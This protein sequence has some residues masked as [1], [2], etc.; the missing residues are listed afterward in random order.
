MLLT[1][2]NKKIINSLNYEELLRKWRFAKFNDTWLM[3]E[4]GSYWEECMIFL[5]R[6]NPEEAVRISKK[7]GW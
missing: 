7:I 1:S 4:T 2:K 3:G 5:K 6:Q